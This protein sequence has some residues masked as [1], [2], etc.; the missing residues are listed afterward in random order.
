[1][2][3]SLLHYRDG[4]ECKLQEQLCSVEMMFHHM[5]ADWDSINQEDLVWLTPK[6]LYD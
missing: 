1:M 2:R 4:V 5:F 6:V 3:V